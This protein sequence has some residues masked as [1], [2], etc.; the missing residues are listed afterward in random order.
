MEPDLGGLAVSLRS[1]S[2]SIL[3]GLLTAG[4]AVALP[5]TGASASVSRSMS[6]SSVSRSTSVTS[7]TPEQA[8]RSAAALPFGLYE[9]GNNA[10][11]SFPVTPQYAI[12]YYG[13]YESFQT[14]DAQAAWNGGTETFAELQT[15]GNPCN[16]STSIPIENVING[17]YDSYLQDFATQVAAFG[18]PV[19]LTFDHEMNG[20]WYPWGD[21]EITPAQW[22]AAWQHVTSVISAIAPNA[23][24]VW[25]P[26][27]EQGAAPV[28]GYWPGNGYSD[29]NVNVVGLDGYLRN[30]SS[31]WAN[32]FSKSLADV[33]SASG[34]GY[35]FM[36]TETAVASAD[37][38]AVSQIDNLVAGARSAGAAA[39]MYFDSGTQ[40]A[41]TS[42][43]QSEFVND[44]G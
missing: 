7:A 17:T 22:I 15:C 10:Q 6:V 37:S 18:H 28:A 24:W 39:L 42:A 27:I 34:G 4:V 41:F 29:P 26:N 11:Y 5:S 3:A 44:V 1:W 8:R 31:T 32:T 30:S 21:T 19:L 12:Q 23:E 14:A 25:A 13:W 20:D 36:V 40:W 9:S 35:P 33:T 38:N 43:G 16:S 2:T